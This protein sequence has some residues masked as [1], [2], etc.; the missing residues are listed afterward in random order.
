MSESIG[1]RIKRLREARGLKQNEL[2]RMLADEGESPKK[3][4]GLSTRLEN[5]KRG[6]NPSAETLARY[7]RALGTTLEYIQSGKGD[8]NQPPVPPPVDE[9]SAAMREAFIE[10]LGGKMTDKEKA[11]LRKLKLPP[12]IDYGYLHDRLGELRTAAEE[13]DAREADRK[14]R[15]SRDFTDARATPVPKSAAKAPTKKAKGNN[16]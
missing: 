9:H 12:D 11:A 5:E 10:V 4:G 6:R 7:A 14:R 3:Y 13:H 16:E 1:Q 8:P 15:G 2:D